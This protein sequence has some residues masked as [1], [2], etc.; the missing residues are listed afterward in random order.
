MIN[1]QLF[2]GNLSTIG[3]RH[4]PLEEEMDLVMETQISTFL[5]T[6]YKRNWKPDTNVK[7]VVN[8]ITISNIIAGITN[9]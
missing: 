7:S 1:I 9:L 5:G 8:D 2:H 4:S 3:M 6:F